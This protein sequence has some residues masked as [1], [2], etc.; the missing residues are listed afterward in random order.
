MPANGVMVS[1]ST[2]RIRMYPEPAFMSQTQEI[3][4][5][6]SEQSLNQNFRGIYVQKLDLQGNRL[7]GDE[8]IQLIALSGNDYGHFRADGFDDKVICVYQ[9]AEFGNSLQTKMQAFMLD[10]NGG[11]VWADQFIDLSTMQSEKLHNV[12]THFYE[13]QWVTVWQDRRNDM[14]DIYA[15]NIQP[16]G[17]LGM[18]PTFTDAADKLKVFTIYPNPFSEAFYFNNLEP[19]S[20]PAMLEVFDIVGD[21]V[22]TQP[23]NSA[24]QFILTGQLS[25][26]LYF[27]RLITGSGELL[28]SKAIKN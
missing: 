13:G 18:V 15:Q 4:I 9:A 27:I 1:T 5:V 17:T 25:H 7:W 11:F 26:G 16:D 6:F 8:G 22:M 20:F 12:M 24:D 3:V 28:H 2:D 23:I 10:S 21:K 14:G 19:E